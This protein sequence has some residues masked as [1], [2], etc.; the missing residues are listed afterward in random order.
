MQLH[1]PSLPPRPAAV[2]TQ[3]RGQVNVAQRAAV[4]QTRRRPCGAESRQPP[5]QPVVRLHRRARVVARRLP[6]LQKP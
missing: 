6:A 2:R 5:P 1:F 3:R 4:Q